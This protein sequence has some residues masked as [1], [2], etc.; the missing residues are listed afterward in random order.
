M[1]LKRVYSKKRQNHKSV[2]LADDDSICSSR[3]RK[4][5]KALSRWRE[6][7]GDKRAEGGGGEA[8]VCN[9]LQKR[10]DVSSTSNKHVTKNSLSENSMAKEE[11]QMMSPTPCSSSFPL[12]FGPAGIPRHHCPTSQ[13]ASPARESF[14]PH[15]LHLTAEEIAATSLIEAETCPELYLTESLS[16][17]HSSPA[18]LK[19]SPRS[20]EI[21]PRAPPSS[22]EGPSNRSHEL[23]QLQKE[24]PPSAN[25]TKQP[26]HE[27]PLSPQSLQRKSKF[28]TTFPAR[29]TEIPRARSDSA[30][31]DESRSVTSS[32]VT[33]LS[34]NPTMI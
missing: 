32:Y 29:G 31:V 9:G 15:L 1:V 34:C 17:A 30:R 11:T 13:P 19:S 25:R 20:V 33:A 8:K 28:Q 22:S 4:T 2:Y 26:S 21:K 12:S 6:E 16:D 27:A 18:S 23:D 3:A 24:P 10:R 5:V 14:L 7:K